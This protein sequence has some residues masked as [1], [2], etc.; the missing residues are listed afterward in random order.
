MTTIRRSFKGEKLLTAADLENHPEAPIYRRE[1][2]WQNWF[3]KGLEIDGE[4]KQIPQ[5][6]INKARYTS[7]EAIWEVIGDAMEHHL[8]VKRG[9]AKKLAG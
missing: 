8:P 5:K 2:T 6:V 3:K 7:I 4:L 9:R 1:K